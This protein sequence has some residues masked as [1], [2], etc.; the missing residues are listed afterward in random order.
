MKPEAHRGIRELLPLGRDE[1]PDASAGP[2]QGDPADEED[3]QHDVREGGREVHHLEGPTDGLSRPARPAQGASTEA[4]PALP[5][6]RGSRGLGRPGGFR[7]LCQGWGL[8]EGT[9]TT[10]DSQGTKVSLWEDT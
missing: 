6:G 3:H 5:P 1:V 2:R 10:G 8:W 7:E 4:Q 9:G